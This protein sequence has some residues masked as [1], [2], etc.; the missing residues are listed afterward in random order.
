MNETFEIFGLQ[1]DPISLIVGVLTILFGLLTFVSVIL[2]IYYQ[3]KNKILYRERFSYSWDDVSQGVVQMVQYSK[4]KRFNPDVIIT[5]SGAAG[6]I[7]NLYL[8][9]LRDR[10]PFY[11]IMITDINSS[12]Q[13]N[14][15]GYI[16]VNT[17]RHT[18][19]IPKNLEEIPTT[20]KVLLI[21]AVCATGTNAKAIMDFLSN[22][23]I[24]RKKYISLLRVKPIHD[25]AIKPDFYYF[26]NP[27][28]EWYWPWGKGR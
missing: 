14:P 1:L 15:N 20:S 19:Y 16:K 13:N 5:F 2:M 17:A 27:T 18:V 22:I 21:D 8:L 11:Q 7:A 28:T 6:L 10:K 12:W 25:I 23:G 24:N 4:R 9:I 3:K 26:D